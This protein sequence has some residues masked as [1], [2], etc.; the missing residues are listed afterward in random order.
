MRRISYKKLWKL[1]IDIDINKIT[2][3]EM[4]GISPSTLTKMVKC[5]LVNLDVIV[6]ICNTLDCEVQDILELVPATEQEEKVLKS[7]ERAKKKLNK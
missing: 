6:K 5:E 7:V 1:L 4:A 2:L 3:A